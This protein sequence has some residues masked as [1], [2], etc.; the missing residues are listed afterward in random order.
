VYNE[1]AI[2]GDAHYLGVIDERKKE[3]N[4]IILGPLYSTVESSSP[5]F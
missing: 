5:W 4:L 2:D 1:E 3:S